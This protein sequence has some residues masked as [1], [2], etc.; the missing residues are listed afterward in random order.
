[1]NYSNDFF[2]A[3]VHNRSPLQ[4]IKKSIAHEGKAVN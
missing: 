2:I 4:L 3:W 1:M